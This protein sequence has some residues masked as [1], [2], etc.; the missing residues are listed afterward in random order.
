MVLEL[1]VLVAAVVQ[2][3]LSCWAGLYHEES[4]IVDDSG[5]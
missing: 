3:E 4:K 2:E 1:V 5:K